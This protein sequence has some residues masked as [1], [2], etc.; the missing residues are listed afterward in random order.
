[1]FN[2]PVVLGMAFAAVFAAVPLAVA[3]D[4][5]VVAKVDGAEIY[6]SD[7]M[8]AQQSLPQEYQALPIEQIYPALLTSLIDSKLVAV[9]A[10]DQ[11]LQNDPAFKAQLERVTDQLLERHAVR[12]V[13]EAAL[14]EENLRKVYESK[15]KEGSTEVKARHILLKTNDD[16]VAVI[17]ELDGGADFIELA[18]EKSTGPSAP[19]GGDLG[20]FGAGQMVPEFEAAAFGLDAGSYTKDPVQTQFGYH[21]ILVEEKRQTEPPSFEDSVEELRTEVAQE[22]GAAY[23]E[24]LRED[25]EIERFNLDGSKTQ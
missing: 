16:A 24:K 11:G 12:K 25:A 17:K 14:T 13:V 5:P 21:V 7:V 9:N 23:V 19:R 18:K 2:R 1:M 3:Q 6:Q 15:S 4:D 22:A 10:R 8:S 20:F